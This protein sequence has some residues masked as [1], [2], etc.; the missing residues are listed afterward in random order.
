MNEFLEYWEIKNIYKSEN[1]N[2]RKSKIKHKITKQCNN[3]IFDLRNNSCDLTNLEALNQ[4]KQVYNDV[5]YRHVDKILLLGK[6]N[7]IRCYKRK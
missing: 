7:F 5:R 4:V 2:S 6:N 1:L 3:F